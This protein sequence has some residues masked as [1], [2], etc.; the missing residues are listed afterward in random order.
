MAVPGLLLGLALASPA[1][2]TPDTDCDD[3][4]SRAIAQAEFVL[5]GGSPTYNWHGLDNDHDGFACEHT[6]YPGEPTPPPNPGPSGCAVCSPTPSPSAHRPSPSPSQPATPSEPAEPAEP[7]QP[8]LP[9]TGPSGAVIAGWGA[10]LLLIGIG[11][12]AWARR[13]REP[14]DLRPGDDLTRRVSHRR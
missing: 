2:A 5:H 3:Y 12:T 14:R 7:G 1:A 13:R 6:Q 10:G 9:V 8:Q 4:P 11:A